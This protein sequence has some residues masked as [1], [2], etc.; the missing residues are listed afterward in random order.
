M[1]LADPVDVL[2]RTIYGEDRG[3]GREGMEAVA[4]VILNRAAHPRWWGTDVVSVCLKPAQFSCWN[5]DDPNRAKIEAATG[6]DPAFTIALSVADAAVTG[7]LLDPTDGADSY[8]AFGT[9]EP[10]WA[11]GLVPTALIG[12]QRFYRVELPAPGVPSVSA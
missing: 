5:A 3:G 7:R 10:D 2:S 6:A 4:S 1:N 12:G 11:R 8:F 9:P